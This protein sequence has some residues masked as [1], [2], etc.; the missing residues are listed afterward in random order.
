MGETIELCAGIVDKPNVSWRK[1][2]QEEIHEE[3]GYK[4]NENDIESIKTF[5]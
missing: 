1:H 5:V 3:C 4:V 2:M